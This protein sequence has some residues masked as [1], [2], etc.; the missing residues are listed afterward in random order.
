MPEKNPV[1]VVRTLAELQALPWTCVMIGDG[2]ERQTVEQEIDRFGLNGR[3]TV[4][5]WVT[6]D[7]VMDWFARSDV[8]FMPSFMEGLPIVGLQGLAMGL[9]IIATR[10]GGFL[11][12]VES[13]RN[14]YQFRF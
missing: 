13:Q 8:L 3:F 2:P 14:G 1:Q 12:L 6:Q 9:A 5:G 4:T 7:E 10:V 11:D